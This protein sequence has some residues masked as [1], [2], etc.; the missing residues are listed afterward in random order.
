M[1]V[2][3]GGARWIAIQ[4]VHSGAQLIQTENALTLLSLKMEHPFRPTMQ[5]K[6]VGIFFLTEPEGEKYFSPIDKDYLIVGS[7]GAYLMLIPLPVGR[8]NLR[9]AAVDNGIFLFAGIGFMPILSDFEVKPGTAT[10]LGR[11]EGHT[12]ERAEG[13]FR[14]G[15]M[16]PVVNQAAHGW[17]NATWEVVIKDA[18]DIDLPNF[19]TFFPALKEANIVKQ[20]L[21]PFDRQKAQA[22]WEKTN[23]GFNVY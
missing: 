14:A 21:P 10:Y 3:C 1:L 16:L 13:E 8:Y 7:D 17:N 2:G 15:P 9:F 23:A 20:I 22:V 12:R 5:P 18:G 11:V 6:V 19:R 4:P